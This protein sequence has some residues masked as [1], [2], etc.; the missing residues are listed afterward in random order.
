[1]D[2]RYFV[3]L[4]ALMTQ[5]TVIGLFFVYSLLIKEL[6]LEFGWSRTTLS[7]GASLAGLMMGF[8][9]I[10]G[11]RLSDLFGPRVV[12][13]C[14][15]LLYG[16]GYAAISFISEPWHLFLIC[17]MFLGLGMG[18]H[19]VVTLGAIAKWF[20]NRKGIMTGVVKTGTAFGQM[21]MPIVAAVLLATYGWRDTVT[22]LG[23]AAAV[24]LVV[25]AQFMS[26]PAKPR[27]SEAQP[28]TGLSFTEARRTRYFWI[29]CAAQLLFFSTLMTVPLHIA[30][31]GMDLGMAPATA[32]ALLTVLGGSSIAGR[33]SIG[34]FADKLGGRM[35]YLLCIAPLIVSLLLLMVT[36]VHWAIFL[37]IALYGAAHGGLFVVVAPTIAEIFGTRSHGAIFGVIVFFG[38]IGGAFGPVFA[39]QVFDRTGA[40]DLAFAGLALM[41]TTALVLTR[42]LPSKKT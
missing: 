2:R 13:T 29:L 12:L 42:F 30:V 17:G 11:G 33:L 18:T 19:D 14:S 5:F 39:G 15:G 41:L 38:T 36:E 32:A 34:A 10:A 20:P 8:Y 40:Y 4:G 9:A 21:V 28:M 25:G 23:L 31:H 35:A 27:A 7:I 37:I 24:L 26:V 3:V 6:E 16:L 22:I 1:M